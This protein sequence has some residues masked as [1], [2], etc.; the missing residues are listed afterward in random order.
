MRTRNLMIICATVVA[1]NFAHDYVSYYKARVEHEIWMRSLL[2]PSV[3][4]FPRGERL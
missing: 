2:R 3:E 4:I 1:I